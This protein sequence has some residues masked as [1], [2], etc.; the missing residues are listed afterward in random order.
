M[1]HPNSEEELF[2]GDTAKLETI[3]PTRLRLYP[4]GQQLSP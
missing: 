1:D 3:S 4:T 2:E